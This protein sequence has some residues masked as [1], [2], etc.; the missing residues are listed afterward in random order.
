MKPAPF[1]YEKPASLDLAIRSLAR[2]GPEA[3]LLAGG[4]TLGPM[5]NLRLATPARIVDLG[6]LGSLKR[7][8]QRGR[9]LTIGAAVT[10]A[11]L[12]D[13]ADPSPTGSLLSYVASS[14]AFRAIRNRGTIGGS[15]AHADP[16]ADW[17]TTMLLLDAHILLVGPSAPR[18]VPAREFFKGAFSTDLRLGEI[19]ESIDIEELSGEARWGY[20]R[21]C[22]KVGE[23]PEAIGAIILDPVR[24]IARVIAGALD[25]PP[26]SLEG[27]AVAVAKGGLAA[28]DLA[29][30]KR[31]LDSAAP[32]LGAVE[33][34]IHA[35]AVRRAINQAISP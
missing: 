25:C 29:A 10:H 19:I 30:V 18:R 27:L 32:G 34:Q 11:M 13:R 20:H 7:I 26:V 35:A 28:A 16:A 21:I 3:R 4:Q 9:T 6:S 31:A 12:E 24:Q 33:L 2:A 17:V 5:L 22:R 23:F 14:I 1:A 8:E 15:L